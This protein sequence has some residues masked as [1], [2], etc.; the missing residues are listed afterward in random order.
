MQDKTVGD[1]PDPEVAGAVAEQA[2]RNQDRPTDTGCPF[3]FRKL[4]WRYFIRI[5]VDVEK[6]QIECGSDHRPRLGKEQ[7]GDKCP[8]R[9]G[10][11]PYRHAAA[12]FLVVFEQAV[13]H[14]SNPDHATV[15]LGNGEGIRPGN[16]IEHVETLSVPLT[17]D[18]PVFVGK[19]QPII[20]FCVAE[21]LGTA[22]VAHVLVV[23]QSAH[24][25]RKDGARTPVI[26]E[27]P[28]PKRRNP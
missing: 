27:E 3:F 24:V 2:V 9:F 20:A 28:V 8:T 19:Q 13:A 16:V 7:V 21:H 26:E 4:Q 6:R 10:S 15:I 11:Q 5:G 1:G 25:D 18:C 23:D 22:D 12:C 17:A 14:T